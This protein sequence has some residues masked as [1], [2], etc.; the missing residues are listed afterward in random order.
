MR[1]QTDAP[2]KG[3]RPGTF[4]DNLGT[5]VLN[6]LSAH[7]AI[8][9]DRGVILET[10]RAWREFAAAEKVSRPTH[11]AGANYLAVCD[12]A[13][14]DDAA[15]ARAAAAGI[16]AVIRGEVREFL[17][18]YPCHAPNA[19]HWFYM[20]A[21]RM[22]AD[23]PVRVVVSHEE[24][25]GLKLAEEALKQSTAALEEQ[26]QRLEETNIA[27]KVLLR[28]RETDKIELEQRV[29]ANIKELVFPYIEKLKRAPL[30]QRD[31]TAVEIIENNL[32][33]IISPLLQR[34]ANISIVLTPQEL[35][36]ATL[37]KDGRSS[38]E[39]AGILN[40]AHTTV[41]FHR[42]N[43][44]RKFGLNHTTTNLRSYLMSIS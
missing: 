19:P 8:L 2:H 24:I 35:Q 16:R 28:Q 5:A 17:Y 43:L 31:R 7:I 10:N 3:G 20:R 13:R 6:S 40:V 42:K 38:K 9:D 37:V 26:K 41:H 25:T 12:A 29:L 15:D 23:G 11:F 22:E 36:V 14:G 33:N 32:N 27:L 18:D 39:I 4:E 44:R 34:M 21:I 1:K 30:R